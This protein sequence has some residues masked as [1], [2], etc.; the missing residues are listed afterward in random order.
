VTRILLYSPQ[1]ILTI[2]LIKILEN[3]GGFSLSTVNSVPALIERL[4]SEQPSV[5][6]IDAT[7]DISLGLLSRLRSMATAAHLVLWVDAISTEF[8]SQ[9][10]GLG[11]R[12]VLRKTLPIETQVK[13]LE[14]VAGAE[15]WLEKPLT[16]KLLFAKRTVLTARERQ[17]IALLAQGLKNKELACTLR[18]TEGTVKV[19]LSRLFRK[20]GAND[21]FELALF[22]LKN[23]YSSQLNYSRP[24]VEDSTSGS[25][26]PAWIPSFVSVE[27]ARAGTR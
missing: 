4:E 25:E 23:L 5:I 27:H 17:L 7:P 8:A 19:Y 22:A 20:V 6:L 15:P 11:I 9:V 13:C 14:T 21:R 2:G 18:I 26:T 10:V 24:A 16:D 3:K 1:P 12:G